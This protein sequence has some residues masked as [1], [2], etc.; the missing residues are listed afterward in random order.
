MDKSWILLGT[1]LTLMAATLGWLISGIEE[2]LNSDLAVFMP[3]GANARESLLL[4]E[5][6]EGATGRL[7]LLAVEG[8]EAA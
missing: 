5:L 2:R 4:S 7:I 6:R 1:L 8:G 3:A